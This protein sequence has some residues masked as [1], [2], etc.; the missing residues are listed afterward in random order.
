MLILTYYERKKTDKFVQKHMFY[1]QN[2]STIN[3][4]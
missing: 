2:M 4:T 3:L 1:T